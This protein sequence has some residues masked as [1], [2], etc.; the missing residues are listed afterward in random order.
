MNIGV[1][2]MGGD[3]APYAVVEGVADSL[4]YLS[5]ADTLVLLGDE[6]AIVEKLGGMNVSSQRLK[7]VP[8]TEV[9]EMGDHPARAFSQ[10]KDSSIA[11]GFRMLKSGELDGFCSAGN[12]GAMLVGASYT[13]NVIPGVFRPALATMLPCVDGRDSVM[14]DV[15]LNPDSKPDVLLQYGILGSLYAKFVLSI[16]EPSVGLLNIGREETK[17]TAAVKAAYEL[18]KEHPGLNFAGNIEG[19]SLFHEDITDVV[20]CDGFIGNIV[21]KQAE[22]I[23]MLSRKINVV[24]PFFER[25]NFE[26]I[27]GTPIVGINANV[28]IGHGISKRKAIMNMIL[29]TRA[30]VNA[31]LAKKIIEAI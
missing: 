14:L 22:A 25:M 5:A 4:E 19:H 10:K 2:I 17:G 1:D 12:T 15:G 30:V 7:I 28:V 11:V 9:I 27:G 24:H 16:P 20:V 23:Y 6:K 29:Q 8:T 21:L 13:V 18:M 26:N 31:N 3:Y